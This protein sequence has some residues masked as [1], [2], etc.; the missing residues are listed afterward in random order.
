MSFNA[1]SCC[2]FH[3][4]DD[5]LLPVGQCMDDFLDRL[6]ARRFEEICPSGMR[7]LFV[8]SGMIM[9]LTLL[10][11]LRRNFGGP[12]VVEAHQN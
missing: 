3:V 11:M 1:E 9:C 5:Q 7:K 4:R 2:A 8:K 12:E 10:L 6:D